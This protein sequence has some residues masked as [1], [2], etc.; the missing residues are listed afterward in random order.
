MSTPRFGVK[1]LMAGLLAVLLLAFGSLAAGGAL[2]HWAHHEGDGDTKPC[3]I[4]T[5][6]QGQLNVPESAPVL[7]VEV[8]FLP[9]GLLAAS[10]GVPWSP[11]SLLPPGRAP[12]GLSYSL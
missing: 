8:V 12:P 9:C 11:P 7:P 6:A 2:H 4:C 3:M 10:A 1:S 5:L